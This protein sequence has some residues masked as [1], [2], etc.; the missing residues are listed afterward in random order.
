MIHRCCRQRF[1]VRNLNNKLSHIKWAKYGTFCSII[2]CQIFQIVFG[3]LNETFPSISLL[4]ALN[5]GFIRIQFKQLLI[6]FNR[7]PSATRILVNRPQI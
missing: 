3:D 7:L 2:D 1:H 4:I 5:S 6:H